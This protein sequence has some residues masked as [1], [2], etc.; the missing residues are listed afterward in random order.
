[1]TSKN[2]KGKEEYTDISCS[3]GC[4]QRIRIIPICFGKDGIVLDIGFLEG[5]QKKPKKGVVLRSDDGSLVDQS[6][7]EILKIK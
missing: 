4:G 5:R 2:K 3:C 7:A 1:M 6:I